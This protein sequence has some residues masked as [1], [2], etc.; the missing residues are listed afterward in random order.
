MS[1]FCLSNLLSGNKT[2]SLQ[3]SVTAETGV[4]QVGGQ[5]FLLTVGHLTLLLRF[6]RP[7]GLGLPGVQFVCVNFS[8]CYICPAWIIRYE[9][10]PAIVGERFQKKT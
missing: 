10:V 3:L 6:K 9:S 4:C 5:S 2:V 8:E 7:A 1:N